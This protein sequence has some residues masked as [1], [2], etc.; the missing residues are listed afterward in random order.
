LIAL[1]FG[2]VHIEHVPSRLT[3]MVLIGSNIAQEMVRNK[4]CGVL[5]LE[6]A[7]YYCKTC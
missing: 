1:D 4:L 7:L 6:S 5:C 3:R 2:H